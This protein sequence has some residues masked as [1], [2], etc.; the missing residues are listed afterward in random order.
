MIVQVQSH[1]PANKRGLQYSS[2]RCW[3]G[4]CEY[5]MNETKDSHQSPG[6]A[7]SAERVSLMIDRGCENKVML[8]SI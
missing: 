5:E 2:Y 6:R 7:R 1:D 4:V 8:L 3:M